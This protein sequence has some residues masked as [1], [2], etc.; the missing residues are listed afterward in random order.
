MGSY[1][2]DCYS[3]D[4]TGV[5]RERRSIESG[6]EGRRGEEGLR[7]MSSVHLLYTHISFSWG[8]APQFSFVTEGPV[9]RES[10]G[11]SHERGK[12]A[13]GLCES[14]SEAQ[15][16]R[17]QLVRITTPPPR[18]E[19]ASFCAASST[20]IPPAAVMAAP[21]HW[22]DRVTETLLP[23]PSKDDALPFTVGTGSELD[24]QT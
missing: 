1:T 13:G 8:S 3:S 20:S 9:C 2:T 15:C 16:F 6:I 12:A 19:G 24:C 17:R 18:A 21:S 11:N 7:S 4:S 22:V 23:R 10:E 5:P 14:V